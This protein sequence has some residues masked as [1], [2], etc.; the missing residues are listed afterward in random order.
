MAGPNDQGRLTTAT[1]TLRHCL[2]RHRRLVA[3]AMADAGDNSMALVHARLAVSA[4][5]PPRM[6]RQRQ[7]W[8]VEYARYFD[9]PRRDPSAP[10]PP[11]LRHIIRGVHRHQ[12]TW[13]PASCPASLCV[14][15]PSLPSAVPV[16]TISI[17]DVVFVRTQTAS[18]HSLL[19]Y[20][21]V[22]SRVLLLGVGVCLGDFRKWLSWFGV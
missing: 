13:I 9:T 5:A 8:E 19:L 10:P 3:V 11:G 16:L 21:R 14:S 12:G 7:K 6:L 18:L 1:L 20:T 4:V 2:P 22:V 15:H 17:G